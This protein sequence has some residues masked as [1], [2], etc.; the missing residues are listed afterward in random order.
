MRVPP[1]EFVFTHKSTVFPALCAHSMILYAHIYAVGTHSMAQ[2]KVWQYCANTSKCS[3][4]GCGNSVLARMYRSF[5][6]QQR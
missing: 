4:E 3:V 6:K 5:G 2:V 1:T